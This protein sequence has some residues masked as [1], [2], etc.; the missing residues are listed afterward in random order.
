M[1]KK[2]SKKKSRSQ[3]RKGTRKASV[4]K[5]SARKKVKKAASKASSSRTMKKKA[6]S[7]GTTN[8]KTARGAAKKPGLGSAAR[9]K[10]NEER[11]IEE[12]TKRSTSPRA[13]KKEPESANA[14]S[15]D[16]VKGDKGPLLHPGVRIARFKKSGADP[17]N[18]KTQRAST[19]NVVPS[20]RGTRPGGHAGSSPATA[21]DPIQFEE[22]QPKLPKTRL[23]DAR[24]QEF[25]ELLL[26]KRAELLGD[27]ERLT[28]EALHRGSETSGDNSGMPIHMADL[29]SDNWEQDFT[30]GLVASE[31]S[32]V[33]EIDEALQRIADR[34]YG[35]CLA[36]HRPIGLARLRAKPWA[37]YCIEYARAKEE[38]RSI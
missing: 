31:R 37:R 30:L 34:T 6:A 32:L 16:Q 12:K 21:Y 7:K 18:N 3:S 4:K 33:R 26:R 2:A 14:A 13:V 28:N 17:A 9:S 27:V 23:G 35:V 19:N 29:G 1:A 25:R 20:K 15:S 10:S 36:T 8:K 38:G 22:E 5:V 11:P 24:L